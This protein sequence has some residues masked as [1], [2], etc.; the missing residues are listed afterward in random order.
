LNIVDKK[1]FPSPSEFN[2][3]YTIDGKRPKNTNELHELLRPI[4]IRRTKKDVMKDLPPIRR[5]PQYIEL[6]G[7]QLEYTIRH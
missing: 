2:S 5:I 4:V 3:A 1:A 6:D 7:K